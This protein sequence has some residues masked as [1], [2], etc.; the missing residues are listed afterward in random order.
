MAHN[1]AQTDL[2]F[3]YQDKFYAWPGAYTGFDI[4]PET[5]HT[6]TLLALFN[7]KKETSNGWWEMAGF[8]RRLRDDYD[9]DRKTKESGLPGSFDHETRV[10]GASIQARINARDV[11]W[12]FSSQLSAD[13][14]VYSTDLTHGK[15]YSRSYFK[16]SV[17]PERIF[18]YSDNLSMRIRRSEFDWSSR[19]DSKILHY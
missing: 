10:Y 6:K 9:Y 14:L 12:R 19:D 16:T 1:Q 4:Y 15:F 18:F 8:Y 3:G 5:D 13:E 17:V 7:H 11:T 2:I